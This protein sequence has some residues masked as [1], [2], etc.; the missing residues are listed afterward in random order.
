[1]LSSV[2]TSRSVPIAKFPPEPAYGPSVPSRTTMKSIG[3]SVASGV[4]IPGI[5]FAGRRFT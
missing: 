1:M 2:A 5:N 4:D 3:L